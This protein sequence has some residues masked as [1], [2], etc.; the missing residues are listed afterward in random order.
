MFEET[1]EILILAGIGLSM[2]ITF[3]FELRDLIY[4]HI[5]SKLRRE[6]SV[7]RKVLNAPLSPEL[8]A[9]LSSAPEK[10][11]AKTINKKLN[12][13]DKLGLD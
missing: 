11:E 2:I 9:P 4:F 13:A 10:E 3:L 7:K 1:S 6:F 12:V 8:S 5:E